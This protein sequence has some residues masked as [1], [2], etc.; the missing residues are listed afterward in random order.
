MSALLNLGVTGMYAQSERMSAIGNNI[1]NSSTGAYK[2]QSVSFVENFYTMTGATS[3][4]G[5]QVQ[6]G[7]GVAVNGT[8][9]DWARGSITDTG[10]M[11]HIS[12]SGDG[13]LPVMYRG[14]VSYTRAGDFSLSNTD[15]DN[16]VLMRPNGAVLLSSDG[17]TPVS[18]EGLPETLFISNDGTVSAIGATVNNGTIGL[19]RFAVPDSLVRTEGGLFIDQGNAGIV[20]TLVTPGQ[21]GTGPLR[22][23]SLEESNVD[24]VKE[25]AEM[26]VTQR[27]FSAN[28]RTITTADAMLQEVLQMKR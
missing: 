4:N 18:F 1:A 12:V 16:Y 23:G 13:F 6:R 2:R 27:S 3:A 10:T 14:Q 8:V 17:T 21:S 22:Q 25:F 26:I 28:T 11:T 19:Q 24:L 15:A 20:G 9:T 7:Y 5:S